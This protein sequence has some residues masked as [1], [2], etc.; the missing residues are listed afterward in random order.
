V[1]AASSMVAAERRFSRRI[2]PMRRQK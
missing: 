2:G 1:S